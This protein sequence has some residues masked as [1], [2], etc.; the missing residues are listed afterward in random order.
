MQRQQLTRPKVSSSAARGVAELFG[1][2]NVKNFGAV[3]NGIV[4]DSAALQAAINASQLQGRTLLFPAGKYLC[5]LSLT[6]WSDG[7]GHG[8]MHAARLVG[9]G[10]Y[11]STLIAGKPMHALLVFQ[12]DPQPTQPCTPDN[13]RRGDCLYIPSYH[14]AIH[15]LG[16]HGS[17]LAEYVLFAPG[18]ARSRITRV[19]I[20][21]AKQIGALIGYGWDNRI[22]D[23]RVSNCGVAGLEI[24]NAANNV[25]VLN[26]MI[27]QNR[28]VGIYL[29]G[30]QQVLLQGNSFDGTG[31]PAI[32]AVG[33]A[34]LTISS[35]YFE[36][37]NNNLT[38]GHAS[39]LVLSP[40][41]TTTHWGVPTLTNLNLTVGADIV[42]SGEPNL[43]RYGAGYP[44]I[45]TT[46]S[47]NAFTGPNATAV[48]LVAARGISMSANSCGSSVSHCDAQGVPLATI[49]PHTNALD[50][51]RDLSVSANHGFHSAL[52]LSQP[53]Q[54]VGPRALHTF[55]VQATPSTN[56]IY[57]LGCGVRG[58]SQCEPAAATVAGGGGGGGGGGIL[59]PQVVLP[60]MVIAPQATPF[61][62][63]DGSRTFNLTCTAQHRRCSAIVASIDLDRAPALR[64]RPAYFALRMDTSPIAESH[65]Q[66]LPALELWIDPG[67][68]KWVR[69]HFVSPP[70]GCHGCHFVSSSILFSN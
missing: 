33:E 11:L 47:G 65:G 16:L 23:C 36:D 56:Y 7:R 49:V 22:E 35:N 32:F 52:A 5:N 50:A 28:G 60:P 34:A 4:D 12:A 31:G 40:A 27:C 61:M 39:P 18:L 45:A 63:Y 21:A 10:Q 69:R 58:L 2:L 30:G 17:N 29:H 55:S 41:W 6:I 37:S 59:L 64:G 70:A 53:A 9:E 14:T 38:A 8:A 13:R 68:G 15:D 42:L 3:G 43:T 20:D 67:D 26:T 24:F 48:L 54:P 66:Y 19:A 51:V 46:I 62:D 1:G 57:S 44:N 25:N